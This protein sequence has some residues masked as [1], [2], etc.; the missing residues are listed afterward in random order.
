MRLP[1]FLQYFMPAALFLFYFMYSH[2]IRERDSKADEWEAQREAQ[3]GQINMRTRVCS[4]RW[5][6]YHLLKKSKLNLRQKLCGFPLFFYIA[7]KFTAHWG[8]E[9]ESDCGSVYVSV[10]VCVGQRT[11]LAFYSL[12]WF[13]WVLY[14]DFLTRCVCWLC[15][16]DFGMRIVTAVCKPSINARV[17]FWLLENSN[18]SGPID[19]VTCLP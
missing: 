4:S 12:N 6:F 8:T 11:T 17:L 13:C 14:V 3:P 5:F 7:N 10:W 16:V 15:G 9:R 1:F 2:S 19:G 18:G